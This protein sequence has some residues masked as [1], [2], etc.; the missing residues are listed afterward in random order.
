[1]FTK[2]KETEFT[3]IQNGVHIGEKTVKTQSLQSRHCSILSN[4]IIVNSV[5]TLV[6]YVL[7]MKGTSEVIE[8][9]FAPRVIIA[10]MAVPPATSHTRLGV[11]IAKF[12]FL[13]LW[14]IL[15]RRP[16]FIYKIWKIFIYK[17][18]KMHFISL[19]M[20]LIIVKFGRSGDDIIILHCRLSIVA[21]FKNLTWQ[22]CQNS[23]EILV[24]Y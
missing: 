20:W 10:V 6:S 2:F 24:I 4:F 19:K 13:F 1:M 12:W 3:N 22:I 18:C 7:A 17:I 15:A 5:L 23:G 11:N 14:K 16:T 9:L 21:I 8:I